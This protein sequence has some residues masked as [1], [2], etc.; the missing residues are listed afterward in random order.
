MGVHVS[1][2][3]LH[4]SRSRGSAKS[5]IYTAAGCQHKISLYTAAIPEPIQ[6]YIR[7]PYVHIKMLF[8]RQPFKSSI[9][10]IH[11]CRVYTKIVFTRQSFKSQIGYIQHIAAR[12]Y[13]HKVVI[14]TAAIQEPIKD[15]RRIAG[16]SHTMLIYRA[17]SKRPR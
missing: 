9:G 15:R 3:N 16:G 11:C 13:M 17:K 2:W 7:L 12:V 14:Y 8:T 1:K 6:I 4:G 10:Y 5:A